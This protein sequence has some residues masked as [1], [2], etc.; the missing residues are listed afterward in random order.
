MSKL[1]YIGAV[2]CRLGSYEGSF[3][4]LDLGRLLEE[5]IFVI[6]VFLGIYRELVIRSTLLRVSD[7]NLVLVGLKAPRLNET[8]LTSPSLL[9][10]LLQLTF[11]ASQVLISCWRRRG[12][13]VLK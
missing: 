8:T 3:K 6:K 13:L 11:Y 2:I 1:G 5:S 7:E 10:L 4:G 9:L 12:Q